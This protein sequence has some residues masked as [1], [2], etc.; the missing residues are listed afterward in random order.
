MSSAFAPAHITGFFDVTELS[1]NP[2]YQGSRGAGICIENGVTTHVRLERSSRT[3]TVV[4]VNGSQSNSA[5]V[6][7]TVSK[8]MLT[9]S[10][11]DYTVLINHQIDVP[12]GSGYGSSGSAALSLAYALNDALDLDLSKMEAA[13]IAHLA[14]IECGTGLGTVLAEY[15][16]GAEIRRSAGAPGFGNVSRFKVGKRNIVGS[17]SFGLLS[18][19][20]CLAN[21]ELIANINLHGAASLNALLREPSSDIFMKL[22]RKFAIAL[23][24]LPERLLNLIESTRSAG[25]TSSMSMFVIRISTWIVS[26]SMMF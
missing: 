12:I 26:M 21:R 5:I 15:H 19:R 2:L 9:K 6:S 7:E 18:T 4:K 3:N 20:T 14:E 11:S 17:V 22:A 16:G 23:G 13:Q 25:I 24:I 1:S 8:M 10:E